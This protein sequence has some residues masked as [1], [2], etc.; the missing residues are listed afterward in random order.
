[1][2]GRSATRKASHA[3]S[4][5]GRQARAKPAMIGRRT[6]DAIALTDSKSPSEAMGNPASITSTP[7]RSSW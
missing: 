3:R 7:R 5:S 1:M 2:R 6:A 4:M